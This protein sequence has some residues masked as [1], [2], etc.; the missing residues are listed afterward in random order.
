MRELVAIVLIIPAGALLMG[1]AVFALKVSDTWTAANTNAA[2]LAGSSV[3]GVALAL[4]ALVFGAFAGAAFLRRQERHESEVIPGRSVASGPQPGRYLPSP[5][6][7]AAPTN[8]GSYD[9]S[10]MVIDSW[11]SYAEQRGGEVR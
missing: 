9:T 6:Y 3:C 4:F 1:V 7:G 8:Q 2:L 11:E 10:A 5:G